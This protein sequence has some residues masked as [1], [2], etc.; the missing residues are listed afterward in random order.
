MRQKDL[1]KFDKDQ[2]G[3]VNSFFRLC[4]NVVFG[5]GLFFII[6]IVG[7][8]LLTYNI[9]DAT[10]SKKS[11]KT[12]KNKQIAK[13]A[14]VK[15]VVTKKK[16]T[17]PRKT[18]PQTGTIER[19]QYE[20][21]KVLGK[22]N[23]GKV[24]LYKVEGIGNNIK[25]NFSIDDNLSNG[26]IK[27]GAKTDIIKILKAVQSSGYDYNE[28]TIFGTFALTDKFGNSEESVVVKASYI[29]STINKINWPN[30][31]YDNVY[32]I[33]DYVWLHPAFR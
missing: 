20:V 30:F 24:K 31:L 5:V 33:A 4:R 2:K 32:D 16:Q 10:T 18:I 3:I 14:P 28:V 19:L 12:V 6:L 22:S 7:V 8:G 25:V 26:W 17:E 21:Q 15:A 27:D 13:P 29:H 11:T 23:R 9:P 1:I